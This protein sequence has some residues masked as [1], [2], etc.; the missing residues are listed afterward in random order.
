MLISVVSLYSVIPAKAGIQ[1]PQ[2]FKKSIADVFTKRLFTEQK[3]DFYLELK[4][5]IDQQ[6]TS[7][8]N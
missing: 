8:C 6:I 1:V 2:F 3:K 5:T 4:K 7:T